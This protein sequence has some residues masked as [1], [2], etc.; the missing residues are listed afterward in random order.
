MAHMFRETTAFNQ[1]IGSWDT[2]KVTSMGSMFQYA[3]AAFNQAIGSW[4]TSQVTNMEYTFFNAA[5]FYQDI[6]GWSGAARNLHR[7]VQRRHRV[8]RSARARRQ[9]HRRPDQPVG[10][11]A[12]LD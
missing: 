12:V 10:S 3:A 11:Q 9:I 4:D 8:A 5:A 7:D 6:T 2:S 1:A